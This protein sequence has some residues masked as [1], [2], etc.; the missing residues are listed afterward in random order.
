MDKYILD[1][2]KVIDGIKNDNTYKASW[3]KAIVECVLK[4]EM[5]KTKNGYIIEEYFIVQKVLKYYW[6]M[7]VFFDIHQDN[8]L[9]VER[10]VSEISAKYNKRRK[11]TRV[12]YNKAENFLKRNPEMFEKYIH[13]II[14]TVNKNVA[15]RFMNLGRKTFDLYELDVEKLQISFTKEQVKSIKKNKVL[16]NDLIN[17]RWVMFLEKFNQKKNLA[18]KVFLLGQDNIQS[19]KIENFTE[20]IDFESN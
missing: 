11:I 19:K 2:L 15:F 6:N 3:G 14:R 20:Y 7:N 9:V 17:F 1:W 12:W 8:Y 16:L 4:G 10:I 5:Q 13:K 18:T